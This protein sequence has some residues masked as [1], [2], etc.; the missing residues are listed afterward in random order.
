MEIRTL[1]RTGLK[2]SRLGLGLFEISGLH[3]Q[4]VTQKTNRL[5]NMALDTGINFLD[6]AACYGNSES[7]VGDAVS[8]RR[9][10]YVLATKCGHSTDN[11]PG[12]EWSDVTVTHSVERSLRRLRT[13]RL[14]LLQIHSCDKEILERGEI[15]EAIEKAKYSG[16]TRFIGFSGDGAAAAWAV[17][18]GRFDTLQ[19]SLN[20]MDQES[21]TLLLD[22]AEG[23]NMGIIIKRPI[24]NAVWGS[25]LESQPSSSQRELVMSPT[26]KKIYSEI[27][28]VM[29]YKG[30]I[31]GNKLDPILT[32]LGFVFAHQQVD[33]AIVG[34][35]NTEHLSRNIEMVNQEL[36]INDQLIASLQARFDASSVDWPGLT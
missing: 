15:I 29:M 33:T 27:A 6:T 26:A 7:L 5:I 17:Q 11:S 32:A 1:G 34:T 10:E 20:I 2:V 16:K 23:K 35:T 36:P 22:E 28:Q 25:Q 30:P 8:H 13:D 31:H 9:D 12:A 19:T 21:R 14:D 18:S 4:D 3:G 24:G